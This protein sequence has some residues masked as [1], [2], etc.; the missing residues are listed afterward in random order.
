[1]PTPQT[2]TE[3]TAPETQAPPRPIPLHLWLYTKFLAIP[4]MALSTAFFGTI[5]L[6]VSLWDKSGRQMHSIART[7][8]ANFLHI[9]LSPVTLTDAQKL[10][11]ETA[12]YA[13][14]HLSYMDTPV[15]F[16][17]LPFQFRILAKHDLWKAP[18]VGWYLRRSG[19][20]PID[21]SS[22]RSTIAGLLGGVAALKSGMPLFVFPEGSRSPDGHLQPA[23]SGAAFMAIRAG[24]P[25][26]PMALVGTHELLA[27]HSY[28]LHPRP[29]QLI[30][31]DPIPTAGLTTRDAESLTT[32]LFAEISCIYYTHHPHLED[33][34]PAK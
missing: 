5:A 8:A 13:C 33:P 10:P 19:Q 12:V 26:V 22:A 30:I 29:L 17:K 27:I 9:T 15:I 11:R 34:T 16:A 2:Q 25:L 18:F 21:Q 3:Q 23:A 24:V 4:L 31:G 6:V 32:R 20:V 28:N 7:W 14:N 1:M